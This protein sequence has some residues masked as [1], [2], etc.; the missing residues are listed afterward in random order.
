MIER[1][2]L[3]VHDNNTYKQLSTIIENVF[4]DYDIDEY[5]GNYEVTPLVNETTVLQTKEKKM[6]EDV[7]VNQIP[8]YRVDND[9]G[10]TVT[11]G[12]EI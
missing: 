4:I 6:K 8:D 10:Q 1:I 7:I 5:T 3:N 2:K 11:I 9:Y 12:K